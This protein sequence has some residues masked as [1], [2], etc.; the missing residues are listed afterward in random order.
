VILTQAA[1]EEEG[2]K[3]AGK[4]RV[5]DGG[6]KQGVRKG[7]KQRKRSGRKGTARRREPSR[8]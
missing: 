5:K 8:D 2:T 4:S 1:E 6:R 7:E 3:E